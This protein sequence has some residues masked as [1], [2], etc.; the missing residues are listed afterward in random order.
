M[1]TE[2]V[3]LERYRLAEFISCETAIVQRLVV[4]LLSITFLSKENIVNIIRHAYDIMDIPCP[5]QSPTTTIYIPLNLYYVVSQPEIIL[6][7][8][9]NAAENSVL[10]DE[11]LA[12][13]HIVNYNDL[14]EFDKTKHTVCGICLDAYNIDDKLR[15]LPCGHSY[16]C[17]CIDNWLL[18]YNYSCPI[19]RNKAN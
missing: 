11:D 14:S 18:K 19:C 8:E 16:H 4:E 5:L 2:F 7:F 3:I 6:Q 1:N 12:K 17:H 15:M 10:T 9:S 13:I